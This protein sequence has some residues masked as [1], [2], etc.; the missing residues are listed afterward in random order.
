MSV[1]AKVL[2]KLLSQPWTSSSELEALFPPGEPGH[3]SWPQRLRGL[4]DQGYTINRRIK[5]GTKK[6]SEWNL[7]QK[8]TERPAFILQ[9]GQ[10]AFI[11]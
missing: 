10:Y 8:E 7:E 2:A 3:F 11:G 5:E 4:R 6:L 9:S 1:E